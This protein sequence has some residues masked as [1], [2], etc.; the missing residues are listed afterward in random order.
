MAKAETAPVVSDPFRLDKPTDYEDYWYEGEDGLT[1][2]EYD[3]DLEEGYY[4]ADPPPATK[5]GPSKP[6]GLARPADYEDY[7]YE[8]DDGVMYNEYDDELGE[9]QFEE[10]P[11]TMNGNA[12]AIKPQ[13]AV[14]VADAS[15]AA[16]EA[17]KA[18]EEAAKAATE[19]SKN[20]MKG[21]SG[22]GGNLMG[23]INNAAKPKTETKQ[24]GGFGFG[25]LG[26]LFGAEPPKKPTV[27]VEKAPAKVKPATKEVPKPTVKPAV[28]KPVEPT[29]PKSSSVA[30]AKPKKAEISAE[31]LKLKP[32]T[33][34]LSAKARWKW[35]YSRVKQVNCHEKPPVVIWT[36]QPTTCFIFSYLSLVPNPSQASHTRSL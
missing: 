33:A 2:N 28:S 12:V 19:A 22:L 1:Y 32:F 10:E 6:K 26:G 29:P 14:K 35:A 30:A 8:G 25:G 34:G 36:H 21:M 7:W 17:A 5:P 24:A 4:Y 18:A 20:L 23:S 13:E 15:K 3:D 11:V 9:G 27:T 31:D 16:E